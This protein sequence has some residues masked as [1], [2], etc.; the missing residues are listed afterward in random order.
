MDQPPISSHISI[1]VNS[2]AAILF[3]FPQ[4]KKCKAADYVSI[5]FQ[6]QES[7]SS[8]YTWFNFTSCDG[9]INLDR[10]KELFYF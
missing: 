1:V 8:P 3:Y 6:L 4:D 2:S 5:F 10:Y 7:Q 9:L